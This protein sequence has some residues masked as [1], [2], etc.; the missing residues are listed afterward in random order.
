MTR[1]SYLQRIDAN[2]ERLAARAAA[3]WSLL[4]ALGIAGAVVGLVALACILWPAS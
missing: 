4:Q 3:S 1:P 2:V